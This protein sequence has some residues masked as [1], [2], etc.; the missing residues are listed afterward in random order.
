MFFVAVAITA[1]AKPQTETLYL[2][3]HGK[4]DAV[5]WDFFCTAGRKSGVWSKISVPSNWEL[6]GFGDYD[7]G[8][9]KISEKHREI[10]KYKHAF[11]VPSEWTGKRINIVFEGSMTDTDVRI[12]GKSAGPVHQGGFYRFDYDIT[13]LVKSGENLLEVDVSKCSANASVE[14]AERKA[15]YWVFGGIYRPVYLEARP[16][17]CLDW[18]S[19]DAQADGSFKLDVYLLG[20]EQATQVTAQISTRDGSPVGKPF[21]VTVKKGQQKVRLSSTLDS[22]ALWTAETPNLYNLTLKLQSGKKVLHE[23]MRTFGFRTFDVRAG[24]GI[25]LNGERIRL[26]GVDRHSFWPDSGRCL[27][28]ALSVADVHL[29]KEMNMNAVRMSHYPP[30]THFLEAC[31]ELGLYVLDE[32]TG[33]QKPAYDT[34]TARR[35]VKQ[36]V[37]RDQ[38]HPSILFWDNGNEGGWNTDVDGDFDLYDI[39]KR[40]VL[41]PWETINNMDTAHYRN[42]DV[43]CKK[44]AGDTIHMP[45]EFLHGLYDGGHGAGLN[46]YWEKIIASDLGAGGFLWVFA[47]E[48]VVRTDKNGILD[49][50]GNHAPDGI[51][52][53]YREKEGSFYTIQEIWSPVQIMT[54]E[55]PSDFDGTLTIE[56][57]YSF[58][59]LEQCTF[60]WELATFAPF[61]ADAPTTVISDRGTLCGP[62][63]AP[64]KSGILKLPLPTDWR[65][66]DMLRVS[67]HNPQGRKLFTWTWPLQQPGVQVQRAVPHLT[68]SPL[69]VEEVDNTIQVT[70]GNFGA[71]FDHTTGRLLGL[72][73]GGQPLS[74]TQGPRVV[75]SFKKGKA[76][77]KPALKIDK[78]G[79][80]SV[81]I[82]VTSPGEGLDQLTWVVHAEGYLEMSCAYSCEGSYDFHGITFSY[83]EDL[84]RSKSYLGDGPYRVWKNRMKG[85]QFGIWSCAYNDTA[86]G[87]SWTYPEFK[88]YFSNVNWL[89]LHTQEGRFTVATDQANLFARLFEPKGGPDPAKTKIPT[90]SGDISF[91]HAIPP[92]GTKFHTAKEL[93]PESQR[94]KATGQYKINLF[95]F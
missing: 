11:T 83:P 37:K 75:H 77:T 20:I 35:I 17:E 43:H 23:D 81:V 66:A 87:A 3:G 89:T 80:E 74:L 56:N 28:R 16:R 48:G 29:I 1:D 25:F 82:E 26:K 33:W 45:T 65:A 4:D 7:Y 32:L 39:Q 73:K 61:L 78:Q 64:G 72:V 53:P 42:Y 24:K 5:A 19:V 88:G 51:V 2:S 15:D 34:P 10:G 69:K 41:H 38:M 94:N 58:T 49:T 14:E 71:T 27:S 60:S 21:S 52:G 91:L 63:I 79:S 59:S 18:S 90:F 50:D 40:T 70:A 12:N 68:L 44:L 55:L 54:A 67:A 57:R 95:F 22:P 62:A 47:D 46:D 85:T 76:E 30:D 86:T 13:P 92:I 31:D 9:V 36:I 93:G 84:V 6:Q 8:H